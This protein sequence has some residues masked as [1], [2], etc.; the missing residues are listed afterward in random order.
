MPIEI[1]KT[2][3]V[4]HR[5]RSDVRARA[6]VE[7]GSSSDEETAQPV[8]TVRKDNENEDISRYESRAEYAND[9]LRKTMG[10]IDDIRMYRT[11]SKKLAD[12]QPATIQDG[13]R[14]ATADKKRVLVGAEFSRFIVNKQNAR[15][16]RMN[17]IKNQFHDP[18]EEVLTSAHQTIGENIADA[19]YIK[20]KSVKM[21]DHN[22]P[23]C[24]DNQRKELLADSDR[25]R[26]FG[27]QHP[28][29]VV[30]L[31]TTKPAEEYLQFIID[32]IHL[33]D[34]SK[35]ETELLALERNLRKDIKSDDIET[36]T[37]DEDTK[38]SGSS[39]KSPS[40]S[41]KQRGYLQEV[42]NSSKTEVL[43]DNSVA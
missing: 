16:E 30:T 12:R 20:Y 43:K 34:Q 17:V 4:V 5:K 8:H 29:E 42:M 22:D 26:T 27:A 36:D 28:Q 38:R 41:T 6:S 21:V 10:E 23:G 3:I 25:K 13:R 19:R 15:M 2:R 31:E 1:V 33:Q 37:S 9:R 32:S 7:S 35:L 11:T 18:I 14:T 39:R 24:L 40:K